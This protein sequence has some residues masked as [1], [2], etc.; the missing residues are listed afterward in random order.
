MILLTSRLR[1]GAPFAPLAIALAFLIAFP[2]IKYATWKFPPLQG[3]STDKLFFIAIA[4]LA[5]GLIDSVTKLPLWL[6]AILIFLLS[7]AP[8]GF[9]L[10]FKFRA[11]WTPA[12]GSLILA[13]AGLLTV[14]WWGALES[15]VSSNRITAMILAWLIGVCFAAVIMPLADQTFGKLALVLAAASGATFVA[16]LICRSKIALRGYPIVFA[17]LLIAILAGTTYLSNVTPLI[18]ALLASTPLFIFAGRLIPQR[19]KPWPREILRLAIAALPLA[20]AVIMAII[21]FKQ[22]APEDSYYQ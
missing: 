9:L 6:R 22:A 12:F 14:L 4:A 21:Q 1:P 15:A 7:A 2:G 18:L 17:M 19:I 5:L 16:L 8:I 3:D 13:A 20:T 10:Q 11:A